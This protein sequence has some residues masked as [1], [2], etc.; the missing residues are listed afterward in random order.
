MTII[1]TV[2]L[3]HDEQTYSLHD[4]LPIS[5]GFRPCRRCHPAEPGGR[6]DPRVPLVREVCR[7]LDAHPDEP[8]RLATLAAR[9]RTTPHR[10]LPAFRGVLGIR[11]RQYHAARRIAR[12]NAGPRAGR[13]WSRA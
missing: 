13:R 1:Y 11:P 12:C 4:A 5:A 10:L 9:M 7:L 2:M 8:A 6:P 3:S